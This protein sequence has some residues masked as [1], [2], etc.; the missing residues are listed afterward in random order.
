MNININPVRD[1]RLVEKR[2]HKASHAVRYATRMVQYGC[3]PY[4]MQWL[5]GIQYSTG[6]YI[7]TECVSTGRYILTECVSTG[8]YI[9]DY[10][11]KIFNYNEGNQ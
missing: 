3:I 6:R 7:P 8:R 4:G 2:C 1:Y 5:R 9:T 10:F 11:F